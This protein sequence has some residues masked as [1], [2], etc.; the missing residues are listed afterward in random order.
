MV[1]DWLVEPK[2]SEEYPTLPVYVLK[3]INEAG[4]GPVKVAPASANARR[5]AVFAC[6]RMVLAS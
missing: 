4:A 2:P 3:V 5:I 1:P 6:D